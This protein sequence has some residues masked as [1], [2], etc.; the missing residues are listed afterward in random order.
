WFSAWARSPPAQCSFWS[1]RRVR[2]V[3]R[4]SRPGQAQRVFHQPQNNGKHSANPRCLRSP[5]SRLPFPMQPKGWT[6][7][8]LL[9]VC[10]IFTDDE[11]RK[12]AMNTK[13]WLPGIGRPSLLPALA[14][15][16]F[17][18][19]ADGPADN[20]ADQVRPVPPP[21]LAMDAADRQELQEGVARLGHEIADLRE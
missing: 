11:F 5:G 16:A 7:E 20:R 13:N 21:G 18:A 1:G 15:F 2:G 8:R 19:H 12:T 3:G 9:L 10:R 6:P 14:L 4:S 17:S